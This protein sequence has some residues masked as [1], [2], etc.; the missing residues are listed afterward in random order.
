MKKVIVIHDYAL[1]VSFSKSFFFPHFGGGSVLAHKLVLQ[2][3]L[4]LQKKKKKS[5]LSC[6]QRC[7]RG[8][9]LK[10]P[11]DVTVA[12]LVSHSLVQGRILIPK[13]KSNR[14]KLLFFVQ[15]SSMCASNSAGSPHPRESAAC[16]QSLRAIC[17]RR[18][19]SSRCRQTSNNSEIQRVQSLA[20]V[21]S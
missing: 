11:F 18:K 13:S 12:L 9:T 14:A 8:L 1:C 4:L 5:F 15:R 17:R 3:K 21:L 2:N 16:K 20:C 6:E 7:Q 19:G 10:F